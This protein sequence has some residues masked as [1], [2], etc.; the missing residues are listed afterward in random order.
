MARSEDPPFPVSYWATSIS[1]N[2]R[3]ARGTRL[4]L[5]SA[6]SR[7]QYGD[8][9][10]PTP[11]M[12]YF[13]ASRISISLATS[14]IYGSRAAFQFQQ[15]VEALQ[16]ILIHWI[17]YCVTPMYD[18]VELPAVHPSFLSDKFLFRDPLHP[19]CCP[20]KNEEQARQTVDV[21]KY[22]RIDRFC[23]RES[24]D[25]SLSPAAH[26]SGYM[27]LCPRNTASRKNEPTEARQ[28]R[29][30]LISNTL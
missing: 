26:G 7:T 16:P 22:L 2:F 15:I 3:S 27:E 12:W 8:L 21:R 29:I 23:F 6:A 20:C 18:I 10:T 13:A 11:L 9:S 28:C 25:P 30:Q 19:V 24:Y 1:K 4:R 5:E 14:D 17:H